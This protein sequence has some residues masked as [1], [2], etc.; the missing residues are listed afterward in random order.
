VR[1]VARLGIIA[2][3]ASILVLPSRPCLA[4]SCV[5][6]PLFDDGTAS[7]DGL[8]VAELESI[9]P[10]GWIKHGL[11]Y[12]HNA[13]FRV[14]RVLRGPERGVIIVPASVGPEA[15]CGL[16]SVPIGQTWILPHRGPESRF[17]YATYCDSLIY[18]DPQLIEDAVAEYGPGREVHAE[19][20]EEQGP[21]SGGSRLGNRT[22]NYERMSVPLLALLATGAGT[23]ILARRRKRRS[24]T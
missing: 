20:R 1:L 4:C 23:L 19:A 2:I 11:P 8:Y 21:F 14:T 7:S 13:V 18:A 16:E 12:E 6:A 9:Q 5:P 10:A 17:P 15:S 22:L 3:A 24:L